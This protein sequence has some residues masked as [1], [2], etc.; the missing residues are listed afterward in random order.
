M[1]DSINAFVNAG[2]EGGLVTFIL[3][4]SLFTYAFKRVGVAR[5]LATGDRGNERFIWALGATLFANTV[6]FFGITYFDQS[7]VAWYAVLVMISAATTSLVGKRST[8]TGILPVYAPAEPTPLVSG[9][10]T[11]M[12]QGL[13]QDTRKEAPDGR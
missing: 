6:A 2:T 12:R 13:G 4:I 5:K 11:T 7:I 8:Q 3:F 10:P 9:Y 1:W